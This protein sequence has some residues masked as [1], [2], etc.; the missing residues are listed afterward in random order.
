M[1]KKAIAAYKTFSDSVIFT[2]KR[3]IVRDSQNFTGKKVEIYSL[4]F[5]QL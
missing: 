5:I 3:L 1:E 4:L 2:T